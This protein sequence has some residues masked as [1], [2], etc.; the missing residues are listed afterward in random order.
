MNLN[1]SN[2]KWRADRIRRLY[3]EGYGLPWIIRHSPST[4]LAE[5]ARYTALPYGVHGP[6][7][8]LVEQDYSRF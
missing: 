1:Q 3:I 6:V 8:P 2:E 7:F 5:I 4:T